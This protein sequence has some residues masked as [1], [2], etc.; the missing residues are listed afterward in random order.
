M[1]E[2]M[3][4]VSHL[5]EELTK[6][7]KREN[8]DV[9]DA[10]AAGKSFYQA[11]D[12]VI[13]NN[14][15]EALLPVV[16]SAKANLGR[17]DARYNDKDG[18]D[19]IQ[20][21]A[22]KFLLVIQLANLKAMDGAVTQKVTELHLGIDRCRQSLRESWNTDL[23]RCPNLSENLKRIADT[24]E[25]PNHPIKMRKSLKGKAAKPKHKTKR[26]KF[27][28]VT[29]PPKKLADEDKL[30]CQDPG[31]EI[32]FTTESAL[33]THFNKKHPEGTYQPPEKV[34]NPKTGKLGI[35]KLREDKV[36]LRDVQSRFNSLSRY[37]AGFAFP[38]RGSTDG[39]SRL[40]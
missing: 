28:P 23:P 18:S 19:W 29:P 33:K 9:L 25:E 37:I 4:S 34:R 30:K 3:T 10:R 20:T 14:L 35:Q 2:L 1:G 15:G 26:G 31:C 17:F 32:L 22:N 6:S 38:R 36:R 11:L 39:E 7:D 40:I 5:L 8:E 24:Q 13:I 16:I 27:L 21:A 12:L